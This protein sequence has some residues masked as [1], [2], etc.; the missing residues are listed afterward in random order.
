MASALF[1]SN[2][3]S[4]NLRFSS[5]KNSKVLSYS[6][7]RAD[8]SFSLL[9]ET[10]KLPPASSISFFKAFIFSVYSFSRFL[11]FSVYFVFALKYFSSAIFLLYSDWLAF[12][13]RLLVFIAYSKTAFAISYSFSICAKWNSHLLISTSIELV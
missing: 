2:L 6:E 7:W 3:S 9:L 4:S 5:F 10:T 12:S 11:N 8:S 13:V 1:N